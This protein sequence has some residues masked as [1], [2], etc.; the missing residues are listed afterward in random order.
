MRGDLVAA[1]DLDDLDLRFANKLL[2]DYKMM[3]QLD[4]KAAKTHATGIDKLK[5]YLKDL[6]AVLAASP[7]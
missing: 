1:R 7:A 5:E 6:N 3:K 2:I 4:Q